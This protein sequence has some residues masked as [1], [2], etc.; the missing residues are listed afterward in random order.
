MDDR[1]APELASAEGIPLGTLLDIPE[2]R[3]VDGVRR[4]YG[5]A[6]LIYM[7]RVEELKAPKRRWQATVSDEHRTA[8]GSSGNSA[9]ATLVWPVR[10]TE[11]TLSARF[12]TLGRAPKTNDIVIADQS[13][14]AS[15]AVFEPVASGGI[16]V[17]DMGSRNGTFV[18]HHVVLKGT[19]ASVRAGDHI[20]V[21]SIN[22]MFASAAEL[23]ELLRLSGRSR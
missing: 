22:V 12:V 19:A 11:R 4:W 23:V 16:V 6:F 17:R 8:G 21:G 2:L 14:S 13:V 20:R 7:G 5:D 1:T 9:R 15:H 18:N 10:H 3:S